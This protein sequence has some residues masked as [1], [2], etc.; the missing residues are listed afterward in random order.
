MDLE[1]PGLW[2]SDWVP[3]VPGAVLPASVCTEG[4]PSLTCLLFPLQRQQPPISPEEPLLS[5]NILALFH[6]RSSPRESMSL[7]CYL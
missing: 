6:D 2:L 3:E 1:K 4:E 5:I 7:L